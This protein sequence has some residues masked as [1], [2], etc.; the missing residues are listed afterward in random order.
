MNQ[1][2]VSVVM[3][4]Y[5]VSDYIRETIK[6]ILTQTYNNIE[7]V[8]TDDGSFDDT[9]Q[10]LK[11]YSAEPGFNIVLKEHSGNIGRNLNEGILRAKGDIIAVMGADDLWDKTKTERQLE[12]L[13]DYKFV[14]TNK[15]VVNGK[16]EII[17]ERDN[18][19]VDYFD[20]DYLLFRNDVLASSV[21]GY[22]NAFIECGM[23][24][25]EVGNRSEDYALWLKAA[26]KYK[27]KFIRD[28]LVSYRIHGKNL[29]H[30]SYEDIEAVTL[31]N[32]DHIRKYAHSQEKRIVIAAKRGLA[33]MHARLAKYAYINKNFKLAVKNIKKSLV[34]YSPKFSTYYIKCLF[35]YIIVKFKMMTGS[36]KIGFSR[37][38]FNT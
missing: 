38:L 6:S 23:F 10:I 29:S 27:I 19:D 34:L 16:G 15:R 3:T 33:A 24:D 28:V 20:L 9:I 30:K 35:F 37:K 25:Q 36:N 8:I 13:N 22:K 1:P 5:N 4:T 2:L 12:Y 17:N 26:E 31:R 7:I 32:M 14:C 11:E 21:I 18:I